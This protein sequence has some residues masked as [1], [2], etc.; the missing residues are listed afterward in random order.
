[1]KRISLLLI[2]NY[3]L[4][5]PA[6]DFS[7][8]PIPALRNLPVN[9]IHRIFQDSEG[10]MWYGTVNGLCRDD[11][12]RVR[13]FRADF[14]TPNLL[15]DNL[16]AAIAEDRKG[17][18]WFTTNC[19]AYI[20]DKKDYRI[21]EVNHRL[22]KG[23]R[24]G[25]VFTTRDSSVWMGIEGKLLRFAPNMQCREY[26]LFS[27]QGKDGVLNGF[28]EDREGNI[29]ITTKRGEVLRYEKSTDEFTALTNGQIADPGQICQ[30]LQEVYY[31]VATWG[32]G[33]VRLD[34]DSTGISISY[35]VIR[36]H[37]DKNDVIYFV[38]KDSILWATT[39]QSLCPYMIRD[40]QAQYIS[41]SK[42]LPDKVMLNEIMQNR[43]GDLWVSAFDCPS[44]IIHTSNES[45]TSYHLSALRDHCGYQP[46]VMAL[47]PTDYS[48]HI[49][50]LFQERGGI[51]L[52]DI[53]N[54]RILSQFNSPQL[55]Y[56]K[57]MEKAREDDAVWVCPEYERKAYCLR[58]QGKG[59]CLSHRIDLS[60]AMGKAVITCLYETNDGKLWVGSD[61]GLFCH[62]TKSETTF[63]VKSINGHVSGIC[64]SAQGTLYCCTMGYGIYAFENNGRTRH[65]TMRQRF[66]S[67]AYADNGTIWLG[68]DGGELLSFNPRNGEVK[69]HTATCDLNGDM[70]NRIATDDYG[71]VWISGNKKIIEYAPAHSAYHEYR[72][73]EDGT[74]LWRIIPT[75]LCRGND[76]SLYF[77]GIPG[78]YRLKPSNNLDKEASPAHVK[79]TDILIDD[80][81]LFF[82]QHHPQGNSIELTHQNKQVTLCFSSLHHRIAH[83]IRYAYRLSGI[84]K[85]WQKTNGDNPCA[86]YQNLPKGKYKFEVKATDENGRWGDSVTILYIERLPAFY[87][88]WWAYILY[89]LLLSTAV[90]G[91][92]RYYLLRARKRNERLWSEAQELL[93]LR[94]YLSGKIDEECEEVENLNKIFINR[95][96]HVVEHNLSNPDMGVE[97][98]AQEMNMSRSTFTRKIKSITGKTPLEF[99]RQIKMTYAKKLLQDQTLNISEIA[100][101]LGFSDRKRFTTCFKEE[102]GMPPTAYQKQQ[103]REK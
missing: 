98:L 31:W 90:I 56:V 37:N 10:Y 60:H 15:N 2:A 8:T 35:P 84:D 41:P 26:P 86:I 24:V 103:K 88:T 38:Q 20:L 42:P 51:F 16:I 77:G 70:I 36:N 62:D 7:I 53:K 21:T 29:F 52:Y 95:A 12:Y 43:Q 93:N 32:E 13:T 22:T 76:G 87:E 47:C 50:W 100:T 79:I 11:G 72:T 33:I 48:P 1:M 92:V 14:R 71:H 58:I 82:D 83:S 5:L 97:W 27:E 65:Y 49:F 34:V 96:R 54:D 78:I 61:N 63:R 3:C 91:I 59:I 18:I 23:H 45:P 94:N 102:F 85:E 28:C 30:D 89:T 46:A 39:I 73:T 74:N 44:F 67:I 25:H 80:S 81:S 99:I 4:Y 40:G 69:N 68:S 55:T 66:N 19:G 64:M 17:Q 9:A 75:A 6:V 57:L 101:A